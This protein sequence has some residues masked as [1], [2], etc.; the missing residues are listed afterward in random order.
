[1]GPRGLEGALRSGTREQSTALSET[2]LAI[3][4]MTG[5]AKDARDVDESTPLSELAKVDVLDEISEVEGK[6]GP[7]GHCVFV[8]LEQW[9]I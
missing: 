2:G 6:R 4:T 8:C 7:V 3:G 9:Y 5:G 1:M